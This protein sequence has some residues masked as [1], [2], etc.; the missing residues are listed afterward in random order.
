MKGSRTERVTSVPHLVACGTERQCSSDKEVF[1]SF[2]RLDKNGSRQQR[3][4]MVDL[5]D[6]G[7]DTADRQDRK[8]ASDR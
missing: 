1:T 3:S 6:K 5:E 2:G 7:D 4:R 8:K